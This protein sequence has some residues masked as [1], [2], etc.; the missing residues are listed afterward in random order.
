MPPRRDPA[1]HDVPD[2]P[3]D[4]LPQRALAAAAPVNADGQ[5]I[6]RNGRPLDPAGRAA[7]RVIAAHRAAL[8]ARG[9]ALPLGTPLRANA[10][11]AN[12]A[13]VIRQET[14]GHGAYFLTKFAPAAVPRD[15]ATFARQ[16]VSAATAHG[17]VAP[18]LAN[19]FFRDANGDLITRAIYFRRPG[20]DAADFS[21][22]AVQEQLDA[23]THGDPTAGSDVVAD[24]YALDLDGFTIGSVP[25]RAGA[26]LKFTGV[27]KRAAPP[28]PWFKQ[29][30]LD[31]KTNGA[32]GNCLFAVLRTVA[33]EL[34]ITFDTAQAKTLRRRFGIPD[35][36]VEARA[37]TIDA[38]ARHYGLRVVVIVGVDAPPDA[39]RVF[40]DSPTRVH[41]KNRCVTV[42]API[43]VAVGGAED[44][45]ECRVWLADNHYEYISEDI[46]LPWET[47]PITGDLITAEMRAMTP[48][49][50]LHY[51]HLRVIEQG[52]TWHGERV[53][54]TKA[55]KTKITKHRVIVFDYETVHDQ[56]GVLR[57]YSLGFL[58]FDPDAPELADGDFSG[59]ISL[60]VCEATSADNVTAVSAALMD[61]L[62]HAPDNTQYTLVSFNGCGFDHFILCREAL[63]RRLLN[64]RSPIFATSTG[65]RDF[66]IGGRHT[67]LDLAKIVPGTSLKS[68][69]KDFA[70]KP[71][72]LDGFS[73]V[74]PQAAYEDGKLAE[75][76]T[77]NREALS[78]YQRTDVLSTASLLMKLRGAARTI[79]SIDILGTDSPKTA[80]GLA[81]AMMKANCSLPAPASSEEIDDF[82]RSAIT[83]GRTQVYRATPDEDH[84]TPVCISGEQLRMYDFVSLYPTAM[85]SLDNVSQLFPESWRFG[86]FP[87][88]AENPDGEAV[89]GFIENA[90]GVYDV[91]V[92]RQPFPNVLPRRVEGEPLDWGFRGE[93]TTRCTHLEIH[94]IREKCGA[95]AISVHRGRVFRAASRESGLFRTFIEPLIAEK[96]RQDELKSARSP[97]YNPALRAFAKLLMNAASGKC[98]QRN[99]SDAWEMATGRTN[100]L[101]AMASMSANH[102][103]E[104]WPLG[105]ETCMVIG[106]K[107]SESV[108]SP[109]R[110]KPSVLAVLI[111]S[112][113]RALVYRT[114][115]Q[116]NILYSDTDSGL[117]RKA[118]AER[119]CAAFPALIPHGRAKV[120]GDLEQELD[121]H[122]SADAFLI[123]P[124]DYAI[125]LRDPEGR[126]VH[127]GKQKIKG[128]RIADG[129]GGARDRL[130]NADLDVKTLA[131]M[132]LQDLGNEFSCTEL[133]TE[134]KISRP[135]ADV[136]VCHELFATRAAGAERHVLCSQL[137][138]SCKTDDGFKIT[139]RYLIKKL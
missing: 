21:P 106:K 62:E 70:T 83:G 120:L 24:G 109:K 130:I 57:P 110:A 43:V 126:L 19:V 12:R 40:D 37:E 95:D 9:E 44:A 133:G 14:R 13:A 91:T 89:D 74:H 7:K 84:T 76:I 77:K 129:A 137:Q 86:A 30:D 58:E 39:E 124:K 65:I 80:G 67:A 108:Y 100:Q 104:F 64:G 123:A 88:G 4:Y 48:S 26:G 79:T 16:I 135:L 41:N 10:L 2:L 87:T 66:R 132:P 131:E 73:H 101:R 122:A 50:L 139:Q 128:V 56:F 82:F 78:L 119:L 28:N 94:L 69:C 111:Y 71:T 121:E 85:C 125:F 27:S 107:P 18:L 6:G 42:A 32:D 127:G 63:K 138:R 114:L 93:F 52:R 68:A 51:Q 90:V 47:C 5:I 117:F 22:Q 1:V 60:E 35:G 36:P 112:Y 17:I 134:A 103:V 38:L 34:G 49:Q 98:A 29:V 11:P 136:E 31:A 75:W 15:L 115:C 61:R 118:D 20:A 113:S 53:R 81:F 3:I 55:R 23:I 45:P 54:T 99:Y 96:N 72:K 97:N 102:P 59:D 92:H 33:R 8:V 105:G 25:G 116:H 46:N